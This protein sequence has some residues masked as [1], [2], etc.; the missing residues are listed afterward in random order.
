M[1]EQRSLTA[2]NLFQR[3]KLD[4]SSTKQTDLL[5]ARNRINEKVL[6]E[7]PDGNCFAIT[8]MKLSSDKLSCLSIVLWLDNGDFPLKKI[9]LFAVSVLK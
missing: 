3:A 8:K 2:T 6:A 9:A 7:V 5:V 4:Y 1:L